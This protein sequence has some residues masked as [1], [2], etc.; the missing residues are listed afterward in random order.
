[1]CCVPCFNM[2]SVC[3]RLT[4]TSQCY[5]EKTSR[6]SLLQNGQRST[7]L[8]L[9]LSAKAFALV[10]K[11]MTF[12]PNKSNRMIMVSVHGLC[13]PVFFICAYELW[14]CILMGCGCCHTNP[15]GWDSDLA[16]ILLLVHFLPPTTKGQ[17]HGKISATETTDHVVKF[18]KLRSGQMVTECCFTSFKT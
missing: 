3:V 5:L 10:F 17:R 11:W 13:L 14:L 7:N 18:M 8:G 12:C 2:V 1:M 9:S 16:A 15:L 6:A 4:K